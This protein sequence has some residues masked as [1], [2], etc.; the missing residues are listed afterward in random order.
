M[1][2][3]TMFMT[4]RAT[5]AL[6]TALCAILVLLDRSLSQREDGVRE[7]EDRQTD[8]GREGETDRHRQ[9]EIHRAT[10]RREIQGKKGERAGETEE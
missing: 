5:I 6:K 7:T 2:V 4:M 1:V 9:S 10:G 3:I 8:R